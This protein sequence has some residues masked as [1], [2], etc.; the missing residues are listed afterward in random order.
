MVFASFIRKASDV[1]AVRDVLGEK[2]KHI[3]II[4]KVRACYSQRVYNSGRSTSML[5]LCIYTMYVKAGMVFVCACT[6]CVRMLAVC[7]STHDCVHITC[8]FMLQLCFY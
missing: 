2:G 5:Y 6:A 8:C 4:S 3:A 1:R 7:V